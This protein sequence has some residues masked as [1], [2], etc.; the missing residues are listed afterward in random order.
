MEYYNLT[1]VF[2]DTFIL[3]EWQESGSHTIVSA[4]QVDEMVTG[5]ESTA[6]KYRDTVFVSD[7]SGHHQGMVIA[8]GKCYHV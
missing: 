3:V 8:I 6:L 5:K 2:S 1:L 7:R 4:S